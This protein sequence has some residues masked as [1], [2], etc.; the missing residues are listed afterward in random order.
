M[1]FEPKKIVFAGVQW[2]V[3]EF[4]MTQNKETARFTAPD[5]MD[6]GKVVMCKDAVE[7]V[8]TC[9]A[10][11]QQIDAAF[12]RTKKAMELKDATTQEKARR[13]FDLG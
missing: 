5:G 1:A 4:T 7:L 13:L 11:K 6:E 12:A 10:D 2:T 9:R 8:I 3:V